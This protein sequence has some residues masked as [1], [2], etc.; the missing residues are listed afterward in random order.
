MLGGGNFITHNKALNGTYI[1]FVSKAKAMAQISDRGIVAIPLELDFG[2]EDELIFVD[3]KDVQKESLKLF[4][5]DFTDPKLFHIRELFKGAKSAILYRLNKGGNKAT[6]THQS[7][8]VTAKYSGLAGNNIKIIIENNL[9]DTNKFDVTT[10]MQGVK[11][12]VQTVSTISD[13]KENDF[14]KFS[15]TGSLS[16]TAGINLSGGTNKTTIKGTY[17]EFLD[18]LESHFCN[19]LAYAGTD[20]SIKSLFVAYTKRLRD[21]QGVKFQCVVYKKD[22]ID[23]EGVIS[24]H[25]SVKED[26]KLES[27]LIYWL[28]G[29]EAGVSINKSLVNAKY[30]GELTLDVNYKSRDLISNDKKGHIVFHKVGDSI[31][32]LN[33]INT[34]TSF[35]NE[36]SSDFREN[37]VIRV[38]DQDAIETARIFNEKYLGKENNN[39][40]GRINLWSDLVYLGEQF[41]KL[42]AIEEFESKDI[43]VKKDVQKNTV[44]VTKS[45]LPIVAMAKLYVTVEVR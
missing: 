43:E 32:I 31:Y 1:N 41:Q 14:V 38:L 6:V 40:A 22:E 42:G 25:T 26:G 35:T 28:A 20:D 11:V 3:S 36:K 19:I 12:D 39:S 18:K 33:D 16:K 10:L 5:Y 15:G 37:Q 7:L 2:L 27:D 24:L 8:T 17:T 21:E 4:G 45:I 29:K 9:D 30:D 34:F 23:Y 13:L 44:I